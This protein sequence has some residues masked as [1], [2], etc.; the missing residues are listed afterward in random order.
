MILTDEVLDTIK[1]GR[2]VLDCPQMKLVPIIE[3]G[4][5][6]YKGSGYIALG[7]RGLNF[8][9]FTEQSFDI[10]AF[11]HPPSVKAGQFL[12]DSDYYWLYAVDLSGRI[13]RSSRIYPEINQGAGIVVNG[14]IDTIRSRTEHKLSPT[15]HALKLGS[16]RGSHFPTIRAHTLF[17][18]S[19]KGL[20]QRC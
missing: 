19:G 17:P 4:R 20:Y 8:K 7:E 9:L 13:W 3:E 15:T 5:S 18:R 6:H 1:S 11:F 14:K 16:P 2:L 10:S 12:T